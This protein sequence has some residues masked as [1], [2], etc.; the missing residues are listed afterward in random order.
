MIFIF[1]LIYK[2]LDVVFFFSFTIYLFVKLLRFFKSLCLYSF[3]DKPKETQY[4]RVRNIIVMEG[5]VCWYSDMF[6]MHLFL[7]YCIFNY[8]IDFNHKTTKKAMFFTTIILLFAT[9]F[10]RLPLSEWLFKFSRFLHTLLILKLNYEVFASFTC[11][12]FK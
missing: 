8:F 11:I 4:Y 2:V 1:S 7:M 10:I 9:S 3:A 6:H 5:G 12:E